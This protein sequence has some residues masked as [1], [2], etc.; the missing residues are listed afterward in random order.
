MASIVVTKKKRKSLWRSA[1]NATGFPKP[2]AFFGP[3]AA[4]ELKA[5]SRISLLKLGDN[6]Y[7][8]T[9]QICGAFPTAQRN[10]V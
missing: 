6:G 5:V 4:L 10:V 8:Q 1:A 7:L 2:D 3:E 9:M